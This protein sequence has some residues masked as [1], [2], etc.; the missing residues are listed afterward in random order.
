MRKCLI[1]FNHLSISA[2]IIFCFSVLL[3]S[4]SCENNHLEEKDFTPVVIDSIVAKSIDSVKVYGEVQD[5]QEL[6]GVVESYGIIWTTNE[7]ETLTIETFGGNLRLGTL[8]NNEL[9]GKF[10]AVLQL[11]PSQ[12]YQIAAYA[13]PDESRYFYS[14]IQEISTG[15]G[16]AFTDEVYYEGGFNF[17]MRGKLFGTKK[18]LSVVQ[19]GFCWSTTEQDPKFESDT[20]QLGT[21]SNRETFQYN[22]KVDSTPT[23]TPYYIRSFAIFKNF[24]GVETTVFGNIYKFHGDFNFWIAKQSYPSSGREAAISFV[25]NGKAY[26]G[27]GWREGGSVYNDF[28]IYDP[29]TEWGVEKVRFT[30]GTVPI[31]GIGFTIKNNAYIGIGNALQSKKKNLWKYTPNA[32]NKKWEE[33]ASFIGDLTPGNDAAPFAGVGFSMGDSVGYFGTGTIFFTTNLFFKYHPV[34][35]EWTPI[36]NFAGGNRSEA[37]SFVIGDK[38]YVGMGGPTDLYEYAPEKDVWTKKADFP[39]ERR[40]KA[41][42]FELNGKG[43]VGAGFSA[44]TGEVFKDFWEY[45]P[46]DA[47][48]GLD[49]NGNPLGR[50]FRRADLP[51]GF[52]DGVSFTVDGRAF[53]GLGRN[54]GST[55]QYSTLIWEYNP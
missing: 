17:E 54:L 13:T 48:L 22:I 50:W 8:T 3:V 4:S 16:S 53:A 6:N 5:L 31:G 10:E 41:I 2:L 45:D 30:E 23:I 32:V 7:N 33:T 9:D 37:T 40:G 36:A 52:F 55:N 15:T 43:Y 49:A 38:A 46:L 34:K 12:S 44:V 42:G 29:H 28:R 25:L 47:S 24:M 27:A 1:Y 39:G 18:G 14:E 26:V 51:S 11:R 21:L 35:D 20:I 19:H